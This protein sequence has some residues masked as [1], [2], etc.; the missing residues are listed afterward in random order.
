[1][2]KTSSTTSKDLPE[3]RILLSFANVWDYFH[4]SLTRIG[5]EV[6]PALPG[7]AS[8]NPLTRDVVL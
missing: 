4:S 8:K 5:K 1:M 2:E 7:K 6:S 3:L